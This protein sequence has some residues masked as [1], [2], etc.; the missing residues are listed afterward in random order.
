MSKIVLASQVAEFL[1]QLFLKKDVD[2]DLGKDNSDL[3]NFKYG[4]LINAIGQSVFQIQ[5]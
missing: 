5:K 3:K 2:R 4:S 1:K